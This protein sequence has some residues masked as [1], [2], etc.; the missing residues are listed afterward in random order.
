MVQEAS[1]PR[2]LVAAPPAPPQ[3]RQPQSAFRVVVRHLGHTVQLP[4]VAPLRFDK[5]PCSVCTGFVEDWLTVIVTSEKESL[6]ATAVNVKRLKRITR[7]LAEELVRFFTRMS[8]TESY[9]VQQYLNMKKTAT[10]GADSLGPAVQVPIGEMIN[11]LDRY[12]HG[13]RLREFHSLFQD[14][15]VARFTEC[16]DSFVAELIML[17]WG[18][19]PQIHD[20][21]VKVCP[22]TSTGPSLGLISYQPVII[23]KQKSVAPRES[24]ESRLRD[25]DE[26]EDD[27]YR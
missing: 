10:K 12:C 7:P 25:F 1:V 18:H 21:H 26:L 3:S 9:C 24:L 13:M 6:K 11:A 16:I 19:L 14:S 4:P 15:G 17:L 8:K 23:E 22:P 5:S 2:P 20:E 27:L